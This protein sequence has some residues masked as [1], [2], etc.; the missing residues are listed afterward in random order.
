MNI[1]LPE[2]DFMMIAGLLP[3]VGKTF[4]GWKLPCI[5][6]IENR[7]NSSDEHHFFSLKVGSNLD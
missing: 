5:I 6:I 4:R 1:H 3:N 2:S 7:N